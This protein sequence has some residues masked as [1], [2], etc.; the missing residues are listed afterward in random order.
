VPVIPLWLLPHKPAGGL[1][2]DRRRVPAEARRPRAGEAKCEAAAQSHILYRMT[3]RQLI[4]LPLGALGSRIA[5][6]AQEGQG[7]VSRG[8][9]AAPRGKPS[10][11]PFN[12]HFADVAK[13]AGL[14]APVIYGDVGFNDYIVDSMG[15]GVA[16][17]DYDNDGWQDLLVLTGRRWKDTPD[18]AI[19]RLY[20][21]NRNGTFTDVT[22]QAGLGASVWGGGVTIGDYDN[23][24]FDDIFVSCWGQ[25]ILYH[26]NGDGTFTDVTEK[27]GLLHEGVRY[28]TGCTWVDY[29]RDGKLDLFVSHYMAFDQKKMPIR[30]ADSSCNYRGVPVY[31]FPRNA[32]R[33]ACRLYHNNG[34]GTFTDVSEKSGVLGVNPGFGLTAVAT[35]FDGDGWPDIYVACDST[36]SLLFRN[37]HDGTFTERGLESGVSLSEDGQEQSGMGLGI[38]DFNL[39]GNLDIVKTHFRDDTPALY[40]G[41]GKGFFRDATLRS[42]LGVETRFVDWGVGIADLDNDGMP[43][44]FIATGMVYPEVEKKL[45][46]FAY[47]TPRVVFR[48]LGGGKFEELLDEAGP[49]VTANHCSRAVAFGDFDNDGDV[50]ILIM[51]M[52]EPPSLLRNDMKGD[53]HWLKVLLTGTQSNRSAIG[54]QVVAVYG[55]KR[56]AQAVLAQ[57]SYLSVNDRRLHFGL[58]A[59]KSADLEILWPNGNRE[60]VAGVAANQLV[61]IKE[62]SGV[63]RTENF[64]A[65]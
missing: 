53:N 57:S 58:G 2:Q 17:I 45:P 40:Q 31:C 60:K 14:T 48:N 61:V 59:E 10:G 26:N 34:D 27:A 42:G 15:C 29:D 18:G 8:V 13:E 37:N 32:P 12:A 54:A 3:R 21:N 38:G 30:G 47:K 20:K 49:G 55:G 5:A 56:N 9:K 46:E 22:A 33:E 63:V 6:G 39:D 28:G 1:R 51:N 41:N 35:D 23:D 4:A 65:K 43:D 7:M 64:A 36:P 52:N 62:G 16:F 44:I 11:L 19:I 24:G 25:N 50:D